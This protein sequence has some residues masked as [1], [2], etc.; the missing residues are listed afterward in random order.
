MHG[1]KGARDFI[2]SETGWFTDYADAW[3]CIAELCRTGNFTVNCH[4]CADDPE[5]CYLHGYSFW[6]KR[7]II[8]CTRVIYRDY[9]GGWGAFPE[10]NP[11]K[12]W[13][14]HNILLHEM[15]HVCGIGNI[16]KETYPDYDVPPQQRT[17]PSGSGASYFADFCWDRVYCFIGYSD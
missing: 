3:G 8:L 9:V 12:R 7:Q 11:P 4:R 2:N 15:A 1:D 5:C 17:Y 14:L 16:G 13:I 6:R 10:D